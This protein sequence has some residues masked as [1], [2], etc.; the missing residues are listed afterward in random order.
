MSHHA[1]LVVGE[2][3]AAR[4]RVLELLGLTADS[5][6]GDPDVLSLSFPTFG[7]DDARLL[8][9]FANQMPIGREF[10]SFIISFG[11]ITQETQHALLK[12][13]EE[14]PRGSRFALIASRADR[15]LPTLRS[16]LEVVPLKRDVPKTKGEAK[17][18]VELAPGERLRYIAELLKDENRANIDPFLD[19]L[20]SLIHE[21]GDRTVLRSLLFVRGY[22]GRRGSSPKMLLEHLALSV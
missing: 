10:R 19:G 12:L 9:R 5:L 21:G 4:E 6:S 13:F 22:L 1:Y 2:P 18:F 15:I 20:E 3:E 16:R 17:R 14:P 7:I 11:D 8:E